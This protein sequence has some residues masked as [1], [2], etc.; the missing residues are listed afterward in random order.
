MI[1][2]L[3]GITLVVFFII[4]LAPGSPIEQQIQALK[5]SSGGQATEGSSSMGEVGV[6]QEA[7]DALKKQ[8]GFDK[9]IYERY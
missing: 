1:P 6:S 7:L 4:N 5:F 2:T 9:P 3:F 8:Y